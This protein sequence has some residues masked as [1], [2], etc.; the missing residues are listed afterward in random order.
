[1]QQSFRKGDENMAAGR[2]DAVTYGL[3]PICMVVGLI[4]GGI[5]AYDR[6]D[7][8]IDPVGHAKAE[9]VAASEKKASEA[10]EAQ[11]RTL[12]AAARAEAQ[13]ENAGRAEQEAQLQADAES[14]RRTRVLEDCMRSGG[15]TVTLE[16]M[17]RCSSR[18]WGDVAKAASD[19]D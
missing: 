17:D 9:A 1:L 7:A 3:L 13:R 15:A 2:F 10:S 16:N 19:H 4:W 5:W 14:G 8:L 18:A 12:Q 6:L 11:E